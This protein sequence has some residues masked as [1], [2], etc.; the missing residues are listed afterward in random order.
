VN[1]LVAYVFDRQHVIVLIDQLQADDASDPP[2][3]DVVGDESDCSLL[4]VAPPVARRL[5]EPEAQRR[6]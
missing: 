5:S 3:T 1:A 6:P 2:S 4:Q